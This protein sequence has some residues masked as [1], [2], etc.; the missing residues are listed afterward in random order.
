MASNC[1]ACS[2]PDPSFLRPVPATLSGWSHLTNVEDVN[3]LEPS[4]RY[5]HLLVSLNLVPDG[6]GGAGRAVFFQNRDIFIDCR[7][8]RIL[9]L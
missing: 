8:H 2:F 7:H 5:E 6:F 1:K 3:P 9:T 4:I